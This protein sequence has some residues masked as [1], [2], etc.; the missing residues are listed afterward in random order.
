MR[1]KECRKKENKGLIILV[2]EQKSRSF[3]QEES[4][5]ETIA[6]GQRKAAKAGGQP[7][8]TAHVHSNGQLQ[9]KPPEWEGGRP[10]VPRLP[11]STFPV[12]I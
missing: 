2:I 1:G 4:K 3:P 8:E 7:N 9:T 10:R 6:A 12:P 11:S 5:E